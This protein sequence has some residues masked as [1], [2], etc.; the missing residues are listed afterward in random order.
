MRPALRFLTLLGLIGL[1]LASGLDA[2]SRRHSNSP[3]VRTYAARSYSRHSHAQRISARVYRTSRVYSRSRSRVRL[4]QR[5]AGPKPRVRHYRPSH[6]RH[7][8]YSRSVISRA[9]GTRDRRGRLRRSSEAKREFMR[10]TGYSRGRPGYVVDHVV[11]LACG[12]SDT[13]SNMQWQSREA[14]REKDRYERRGCRR[15]R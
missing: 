6:V 15:S 8:A 4:A 11:P 3:R 2:Q 9:P 12:G 14:A 5:Y 1:V 13:P 7:R 10:R